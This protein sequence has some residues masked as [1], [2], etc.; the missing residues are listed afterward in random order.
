[1]QQQQQTVVTGAAP[2]QPVFVSQP[3]QTASVSS[4]YGHRQSGIVG[5]QLIISGCL[6]LFLSVIELVITDWAS[7]AAWS[8]WC[9]SVLVSKLILAYTPWFK[10]RTQ[11]F[12]NNL[13]N[14]CAWHHEEIW[15]KSTRV[16]HTS[17]KKLSYRRGT[18]WWVVSVEVLPMATQ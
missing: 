3:D 5:T 6:S 2:V 10:T 15:H 9:V 1:M 8:T 13:V 12:S 16:H 17:N 18:A 14:F 4:T 7:G 11:Y